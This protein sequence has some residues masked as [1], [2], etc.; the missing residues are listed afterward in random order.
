METSLAH[1]VPEFTA[2]I[3]GPLL[4]FIYMLMLD[5][6]LALLSLVP[7]VIGLSV[8]MSVMNEDYQK[9]FQ[10]SVSIGQRM[11]NAIVEYING[12]EVIKTFN[13]SEN[14]YKNIPMQSMTMQVFI[15]IGWT[16]A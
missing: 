9:N 1:L 2:N 5:W 8:T 10:K 11:N 3:V 15:T 4:L 7:L 13:Q 16:K 12:I 14:S 6:R